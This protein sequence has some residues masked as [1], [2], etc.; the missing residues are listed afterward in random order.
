VRK[1]ISLLALGA[2]F[3]CAQQGFPPGG[4]PDKVPPK[5]LKTTPDSN[6]RNV[7]EKEVDFQFDEVLSERP[8]GATS[9]DALVLISPR[10]GA[11]RVGWHRSRI[12]VRGHKDWKPNTT[13]VITLLPGIADLRGNADKFEHELIF[14]TGPEIAGLSITGTVF[15]WPA[16][17]PAPNAI[18]EAVSH[19]DSTV[20]IARADSVGRFALTHIPAGNFTVFGWVDANSNHDRDEHEMQDSA[21]V[22]LKDSARVELLAF[23]HDSIGPHIT[24]VEVRDSLTLHATFDKPVDPKQPLDSAHI[25]L[26]RADSSL[27]PIKAIVSAREIDKQ[28][29][30]SASRAD[31]IRAR[32]DTAFRRL[33][34]QQHRVPTDS[35]ARNAARRAAALAAL[36]P[37][38]PVPISDILISLS[39]PLASGATYRVESKDIHNLMGV[40]ANSIRSFTVPK[41]APPPPPGKNGAAPPSKADSARGRVPGAK[42]APPGAVVPPAVPPAPPPAPPS[43]APTPAPAPVDTSKKQPPV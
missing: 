4:P 22:A 17:H 32:T 1:L 43:P 37:S 18:V 2:L 40:A 34:Q 23:I 27:V 12:S 31:S 14:S 25:R 8:A 30:D 39:Q 38:K 33:Y 19:P 3:A 41:P 28:R 21:V 42:A 15:D 11:P 26:L 29:N 36:T 10:D 20:Y 6:A 24:T 35:N 16:G 5:L 9:L 13:Y 7:S